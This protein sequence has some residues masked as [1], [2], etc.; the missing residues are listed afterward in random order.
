MAILDL[1]ALPVRVTVA[2]TRATLGL[3]RL[4]A[5]DGPVRREGG[6]AER[7][8]LIIG[9]GGL[10]ERLAAVLSDPN[11]PMS[12]VNTF[13]AA[14]SEER[15]LGRAIAPD[16]TRD[17]LLAEDGALYRLLQKDGAMDRVLAENGPVDRLLR[18]EGALDR[19]TRP[20][21]VLDRLLVEDGLLE[22][23]VTRDGFLEKLTADGGTLDQLVALGDTLE[24]IQPRLAELAGLVPE[25]H[26]SV[27]AL[28]RA[29]GPL[30]DVANRLPLGRRRTPADA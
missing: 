2:A 3:G 5:P 1:V 21:G 22:R 23:L 27:D 12:L 6:Y 9:E 17:R 30:S 26:A 18:E 14:T 24:R 25:L 16:G 29:V 20:G 13:A 8:T 4:A 11:G 15:P 19:L 7:L 28:N 10:I